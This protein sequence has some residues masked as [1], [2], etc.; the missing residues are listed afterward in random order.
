M[1]NESIIQISAE[2]SGVERG[3]RQA[4][5]SLNNLANAAQRTGNQAS[6]SLNRVGDAATSSAQRQE[7]ASRS[8]ERSLQREIA[9][10]QAGERG[11]REYYESLA[12]QRGI[13]PSRF[14]PLLQQL[15]QLRQQ[16]DGS[17]ASVAQFN[18]ALRTVPAQLTDIVT[19]LVGGQSPFLVLLQQGGQLRDS[20]GGF[21]EMFQGLGTLATPTK[22]AL[23]GVAT[24]IGATS[25]AAYL[26]SKES[27]D[28][29]NT[30]TLMGDSAGV[31]ALQLQ[32]YAAV[33]GNTTQNYGVARDAVLAFAKEGNIASEDYVQFAR[34][35]S[36]MSE[37]SGKD[38]GD[39]VAEFTKIGEDPVKSVVELSKTYK[40]MTAE[41]YAQVVALKEQGKEQEAVRLIQQK[42]AA[43]A[44]DMAKRVTENLGWIEKGWKNIK[45]AAS[46]AWESMKEIRR[47]STFEQQIAE[48]DR[49]IKG[50][51]ELKIKWG[52][53]NAEYL[54]N[55]E[56]Q[57][58]DLLKAK[59]QS[60]TDAKKQAEAAEKRKDSISGLD[61]LRKE[62]EAALPTII[63]LRNELAKVDK[64]LAK[65]RAGGSKT[66]IVEAEKWAKIKKADI[67]E[68]IAEEQKKEERKEKKAER[69]ANAQFRGT[70]M[71]R[72]SH[73]QKRLYELAKQSGEDP[74]KWLALYQ[75]ESRSGNDL[76]NESSGATGH[77]QIMPQFFRDYG[78]SRAGAMDLATSFHAVRR[79]HARASASLRKRLGRDL[80]AGE[81][82]LGHQQGWG[83]ATA[84]LSNPNMN[85]VDALATIMS[86]GRA[87]A[88]VVQ[89]GGRTTMTARQFAGMWVSKA[90]KLQQQF[91]GKGIGSLD[92]AS[93]GG[94]Y[95]DYSSNALKKT[96]FEKYQER[97]SAQQLRAQI[98][99]ELRAKGE[100][101][102]IDNERD[103][104]S[105]PEFA[106]WTKE[107]QHSE[108]AKA[109]AADELATQEKI[110]SSADKKYGDL[111]DSLAQ[112]TNEQFTQKAF[113]LSLVG[114]SK[115]EIE[116]LTLAREYDL[117]IM[118]ATADGA[119]AAYIDGLQQQKIA[120]EQARVEFTKLKQE[121]DDNWVAGISDGLVSYIGS[122]KSMREEV[123]GLVEQTTGRMADSL[124]EFVATGKGSFREFSQS[125]L[126]DISK[127]M[128]KM[129]IF[130]AM[131]AGANAMASSG[132][133]VGTLGTAISSAFKYSDGGYTGHGGKYEPAGIVH[134][135]EYVLSQEKL[136][137]LGGVG[138]VEGLIHRA[139]GYSNGGLVGGGVNT[140]GLRAHAQASSASVI[141][142]TVNV[143]GNNREEARQGA[144]EGVQ[145]GLRKMISEI[146][147]S[148]I[149]EQCRP[150]NLI[151]NVAKA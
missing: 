92:S 130:N 72:L 53:G 31:T 93:A 117:H 125:V 5:R 83:G 25:Y 138:A 106:N 77:F 18:A 100:H 35:V 89:N 99:R 47:D 151:Y 19:Q 15:D 48:L 105:R 68:K 78:V 141:N 70:P 103:L 85:V 107:Q 55:L 146:A 118:Q 79:H 37:A 7:R 23:G 61:Y 114:K 67:N 147:D 51:H 4:E 115:A 90:N 66:A 12:R 120:A 69:E 43:D 21:T 87:Q 46:G 65:V 108:L 16:T 131:K 145:V 129:A 98:E 111:R 33:V 132:G 59:T 94:L 74:A 56:K 30:L 109:R 82:Y 54:A 64:E 17:G 52:G 148:R 113:E 39:L 84:L 81:Y 123:S 119:S 102:V 34:T 58:A 88:Q 127:M 150:G 26:G 42:M 104:R 10:L 96:D 73:N 36:L 13:D 22:L 32:H 140:V 128:V 86:R 60:E 62:G 24:A 14:N 45:E 50:Q 97:K 75:I 121:H 122:F 137:A 133:W 71:A 8:I 135:G 6:G 28:Y 91:G 143:E 29:Q 20:F 49:K 76:I 38:V 1:S 2:T 101:R 110:K 126:E 9:L 44:E 149:F 41:V 139:K 136:R 40:S 11:S 27:R 80:T 144:E 57:R 112:K 116:K 124:A 63:K 95:D 3:V 142:I 134:K